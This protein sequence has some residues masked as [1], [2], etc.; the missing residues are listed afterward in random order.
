[1]NN[2]KYLLVTEQAIGI[3]PAGRHVVERLHAARLMSMTAEADIQRLDA[4]D[5]LPLR[6]VGVEPRDTVL[7]VRPGGFGDLLFLTPT[8][9]ALKAQNPYCRIVVSCFPAYAPALAG[10]PDVDEVVAYPVPLDLWKSAD[11][12]V[13]LERILEDDPETLTTSAVEMIAAE[14]GVEVENLTMRYEVTEEERAWAAGAYPRRQ[15]A[16]GGEHGGSRFKPRVGIQVQSSATNRDY[17]FEHLEKVANELLAKG[18]EV[19]LMGNPDSVQADGEFVNL[20]KDKLNFRQSGAVVETCDAFL[21]PD[22]ALC[23]V[24]AALDI[25]TVALF[26]P[27][28]SRLRTIHQ[29]SVRAIDGKAPCAPCH[30]HENTGK[31]WPEGCP[32]WKTDRCAA[33]ANIDPKRVAKAV[34]LAL[35]SREGAKTLSL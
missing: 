32:G 6:V 29:P 33:L 24:A 8:L 23:H 2:P 5:Y 17:P 20:T 15:G 14:A 1:M 26:G 31:A 3:F 11:S 25:P 18:C 28:P 9:R 35:A 22:S 34:F 21:A 30:H 7:F 10:N 13:W 27:F 19:F 12:H 16:G 4:E